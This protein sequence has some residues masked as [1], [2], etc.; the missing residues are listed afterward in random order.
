MFFLGVIHLT[1]Y[2][3]DDDDNNDEL[4]DIS[5]TVGS[6][7]EEDV[8]QGTTP[9]HSFTHSFIN[10]LLYN[11]TLFTYNSTSFTHTQI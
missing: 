10:L 2:L 9:P 11:S 8:E 3:L 6:L 4:S 7:E 1:G 5:S